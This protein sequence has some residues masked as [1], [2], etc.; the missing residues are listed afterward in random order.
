MRDLFTSNNDDLFLLTLLRTYCAVPLRITLYY[1]PSV[2]RTVTC[3]VPYLQYVLPVPLLSSRQREA[4]FS[5]CCASLRTIRYY[6]TVPYTLYRRARG[7]I[8]TSVIQLL[9]HKQYCT[10]RSGD[11]NQVILCVYNLGGLPVLQQKAQYC[12]LQYRTS[13]KT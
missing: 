6:G 10:G 2:L 13:K 7:R 9:I 11:K 12:T 8:Q 3:T 4:G 1:V 5:R